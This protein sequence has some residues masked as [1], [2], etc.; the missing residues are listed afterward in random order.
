[1]DLIREYYSDSSSDSCDQDEINE[2][3]IKLQDNVEDDIEDDDIED[4]EV[5]DEKADNEPDLSEQMYKFVET[6][7]CD[8]N[9]FSQEFKNACG[10]QSIKTSSD[11]NNSQKGNGKR[12]ISYSIENKLE[13]I[14]MIELGISKRKVAKLFNVG[15]TNVIRWWAARDKLKDFESKSP[16]ERIVNCKKIRR[17]KE[18]LEKEAELITPD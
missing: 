17:T 2:I 18:E 12:R 10:K 3:K 8:D 1:M 6:V 13:A 15:R 16:L 11:I 7:I 9:D 5:E 14:R 4:N